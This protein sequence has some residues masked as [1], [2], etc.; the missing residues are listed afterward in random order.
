MTDDVAL[1]DLT[2]QERAVYEWQMWVPGFG[3]R[4]QRALKAACVMISRVGGLGG[5]VAY[6]LAAAGIGKLLLAHAGD[7]RAS[8]LNRHLLVTHDWIGKPRIESAVRRLKELN[9]A[10]EIEAVG[11]NVSET[12]ADALVGRCDVVVDAAP[13]FEERLAM[14]R[15]AVRHGKPLV[16]CAMYGL[17]AQITTIR[18]GETPCLACLV[19]QPP[20]NWKREF[21]VFGA[22][23]GTVGC[24]AAMEAIKLISGLGEPLLGRMLRIDLETMRV[25]ETRI[26][27]N[28]ACG[29]CA[30]A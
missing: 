7:V 3:E 8:D 28:P 17:E 27:R 23:S 19:P 24:L 22:V 29:V 2:E 15:A 26:E 25:R 6:E 12:N 9:P 11:A 1:P 20:P 13:L 18:P 4:G 16:E 10:I 30:G 14:N 5:V 21:P